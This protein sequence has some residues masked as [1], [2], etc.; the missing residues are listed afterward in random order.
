MRI[1]PILSATAAAALL[2]LGNVATAS[3]ASPAHDDDGGVIWGT[4]VSGPDLN[5]RD[6][7]STS[8]SI[9]ATLPYGSQDRVQCATWGTNVNGD[10]SWYW[11]VGVRGWVSAAYVDTSG[12][13][14]PSCSSHDDPCPRWRDHDC[15]DSCADHHN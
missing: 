7:P 6:Q 5:V 11:L 10:P 4:V 15:H 8:A 9:V 3:A 13:H 2:T 14:V 1:A 12:R